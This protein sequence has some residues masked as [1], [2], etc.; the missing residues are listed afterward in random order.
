[1]YPLSSFVLSEFKECGQSSTFGV[2]KYYKKKFPTRVRY[3][4]YNNSNSFA[5]ARQHEIY[6]FNKV[7]PPLSGHPLIPSYQS[8]E[9]IVSKILQIT[10]LRQK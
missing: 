5:H 7:K 1:M 8:P 10:S 9:I 6:L 3:T 2:F 4:L